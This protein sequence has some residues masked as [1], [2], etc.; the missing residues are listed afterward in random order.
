MLDKIEL[1]CDAAS[2]NGV[3]IVLSEP[4]NSSTDEELL[5]D[6]ELIDNFMNHTHETQNLL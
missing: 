6:R 5:K 4:L 2:Q 1:F 3:S